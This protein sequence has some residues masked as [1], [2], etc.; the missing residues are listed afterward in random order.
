[1]FSDKQNHYECIG[2]GCGPSNLSIASL[3]Y[4]K[5]DVSNV[6]FD[7]KPGFTWHD[8]MMLPNTKLQVSM[9][10]DLVTLASPTNKF[11]FVSYLHQHGR[12]FQYL[13]SD[14]NQISRLE[15]ADYL[16]WAATSNKNICFGERVENVDFDGNYFV[17][18]TSKRRVF[19]KN[20]VI[21]AGITP[22]VPQFAKEHID[23][24][25]HFHIHEFARQER[26]FSGKKVVVVGGGQSGAE[27][28]LDLLNRTGS[29]APEEVT[30]LSRRENFF[31]I[32]D[33]PFTN[34]LFTPTHSEYFYK[35]G[36]AFRQDFLKRNVL[37]SDGISGHT[38]RDIYQRIYTMRYIERSP[39]KINLMPNR[40]VFSIDKKAHVWGVNIKHIFEEKTEYL[41]ADTIIWA[42][43]FRSTPQPFLHPIAHRVE[44]EGT[45]IRLNKDYSA[46]W[47]GPSDRKIF[48]QNSAKNQRGLADPNLSLTAWR[49][50]V[51][52]DSM[53]N[54]Q[55]SAPLD[56]PFV[57][58]AAIESKEMTKSHQVSDVSRTV[59]C[60]KGASY[61]LSV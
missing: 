31:P 24:E 19:G 52:I 50:Q 1:M 21:G 51:V 10:K 6:F 27:A 41:D 22:H 53:L 4:D 17:V 16:K 2:I 39:M 46:I 60:H 42:T 12:L 26:D 48:V 18:D 20:I 32:D 35:Q 49:S 59:M 14:F 11:S 30:W 57:E 8:G 34:D 38:V 13:N 45:E 54:Q 47:D 40:N 56:D 44:Y 29:D 36:S 55:K 23:S 7:M 9:F 61:E 3:L 43:G 28:I 25:S 33:S 5:H 58:W 37:A 15:F